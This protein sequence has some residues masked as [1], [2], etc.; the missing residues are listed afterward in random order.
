M[1]LYILSNKC[2]WLEFISLVKGEGEKKIK[3]KDDA[4]QR[5]QL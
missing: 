3:A 5:I 2:K 4:D 1:R